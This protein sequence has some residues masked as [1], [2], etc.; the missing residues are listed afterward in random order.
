M[1]FGVGK[2]DVSARRVH[3]TPTMFARFDSR[4]SWILE[5]ILNIPIGLD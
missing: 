2:W 4:G 3:A 1:V 5:M